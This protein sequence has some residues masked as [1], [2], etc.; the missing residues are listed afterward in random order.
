MAILILIWYILQMTI[1]VCW[2]CS[3]W[4]D[5]HYKCWLV[6]TKIVHRNTLL[7]RSVNVCWHRTLYKCQLVY[8]CNVDLDM[9]HFTDDNWCKL[10][11]FIM[12]H[13]ANVGQC[14][15][16]ILIW[17]WYILPMTI[18][19]C[20]HCSSW[21]TLQMLVD[22]CWQCWSWYSWQMTI[23]VCWD[24]SSWCTLQM[25]VSAYWECGLQYLLQIAVGYINIDTSYK[26]WLVYFGIA[27]Y[28]ASPS[29]CWR[30]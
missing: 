2:H 20:W 4:Y 23:G 18:G 10:T 1:G 3:S 22:V 19:V 28:N 11:L 15:L 13:F 30:C 12:V 6:C 25:S 24:C 26:C 17:T 21:C 8:A 29:V 27:Y 16:A 7:Y 14:M 5:S 9:I